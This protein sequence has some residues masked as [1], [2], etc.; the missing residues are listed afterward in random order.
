MKVVGTN[1]HGDAVLGTSTGG[2]AGVRGIA[3]GD[4][5]NGMH[6]I[7]ANGDGVVG[8]STKG[9]AGVR[10]IAKG[11]GHIGMHGIAANGD[12]M[13]GEST[14]GGAGIRGVAK[15]KGNIGMHAIA[16]NGD[17][18]VGE[19]TKGGAGVRGIA[20]GKGHVAVHGNAANGDGVIGTST[21]GG[22]GVRG[23][24]NSTDHAGVTGENNA[25]GPAGLFF[26]NVKITGDLT[27]AGGDILLNN[28][29]CAEE[30]AISDA[31]ASD[32]GTVVVIDEAGTLRPSS[33]P[34]DKRV[35]GVLSGAGGYQ[36]AIT[37]DRKPGH[38]N[39]R[40]VALLGKVC[41]KVDA[42]YDCIEVGDLLTTSPT[43]GHAMRAT[44]AGRAFGTV[45]GK[46]L[47][48]LRE[49]RGMIPILVAL[50]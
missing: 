48:S 13:R 42:T 50:Q 9:G 47:A 14:K 25:K 45:I 21:K 43:L 4:N 22:A 23:I 15:G 36:P 39:R 5:R 8:E 3:K 35:A 7:A 12:G 18:V 32:P 38:R 27:M 37:L 20:K 16:A 17:G 28:G 34:Y 10:G 46:A 6:G 49:G 1:D 44:D 41:C 19:S 26:G 2:G 33:H 24:S 29:D 40:P 31:E 30:F 11:K